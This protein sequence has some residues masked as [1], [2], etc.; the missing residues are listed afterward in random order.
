MLF[1]VFGWWVCVWCIVVGGCWLVVF[2]LVGFVWWMFLGGCF[3][4]GVSW[5]M[6]LGGRFL[7]DVSWWRFLGKRSL[8]VVGGLCC[9]WVL[10][11]VVCVL[12]CLFG[13]FSGV[14]I[15]VCCVLWRFLVFVRLCVLCCVFSLYLLGGFLL[16]LLV[17][18]VCLVFDSWWL[19]CLVF[20]CLGVFLLG[21]VLLGDLFVGCFVCWVC[22]LFCIV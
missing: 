15:S 5:W 11:L 21:V 3:L 10:L 14:S 17:S 4:V 2:G 9:W 7:V 19:F 6:F 22:V 16:R 20:V 13:W 1:V 12:W 8:R 18:V